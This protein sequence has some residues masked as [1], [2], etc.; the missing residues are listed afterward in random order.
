M[1]QGKLDYLEIKFAADILLLL[2]LLALLALPVASLGIS[3]VIDLVDP[4][5]AGTS[6]TNTNY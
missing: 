6:I 5:V 2:L 1:K 4:E 3:G